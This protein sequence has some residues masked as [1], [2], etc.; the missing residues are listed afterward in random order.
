M[1]RGAAVGSSNLP[2]PVVPPALP[3]SVSDTSR[4]QESMDV[5][6]EEGEP[7]EASKLDNATEG[8]DLDELD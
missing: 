5:G 3:T 6:E 7:D 2:A 8:T 4:G 1:V